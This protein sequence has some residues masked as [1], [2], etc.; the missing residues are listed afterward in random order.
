MIITSLAEVIN[1]SDLILL[2]GANAAESI[3]RLLNK[4]LFSRGKF[5]MTGR[6]IKTII[7][8]DPVKTAS[9]GVMQLRDVALNITP[10]ADLELVK[11]LKEICCE[12][13]KIPSEGVAGLDQEELKRLLLNLV[14][15]ENGVIIVGQG[16]LKPHSDYELI[17]EILELIELINL[18]NKRGR[19]SLMMLGGHYNMVGFNHVALSMTG[20]EGSIQFSNNQLVNTEDTLITKIEKEEFDCSLIV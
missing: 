2:W 12:T 13:D 15:T 8:I 14:G 18:Q 10:G 6:E 7:I 4:A 17:K 9:F 5:R 1:K 16:I 11:V 20:K 3:P 19:I